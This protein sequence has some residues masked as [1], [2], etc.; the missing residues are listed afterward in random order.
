MVGAPYCSDPNYE[1][2]KE[3]RHAL[4]QTCKRAGYIAKNANDIVGD[5]SPISL[6]E[7][8]QEILSANA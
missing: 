2:C 8:P 3:L 5:K 7:R 6:I 4:E 1:Y